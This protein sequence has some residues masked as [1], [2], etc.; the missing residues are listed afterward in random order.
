MPTLLHWFKKPVSD[1]ITLFWEL[2][3]VMV[4]IMVLVRLGVEFG[5][6][7]TVS[8]VFTP[9]MDLVGLPPE[10]GI[11]WTT[12]MLVNIYAAMVALVTLLPEAPMTIAQIT[13]LGTMILLAHS[14]PIEQRIV[15]KAG[16]S[17]IATTLL[18]IISAMVLG[19]ILNSIYGSLELLT[20]MAEIAWLPATA[21]N[22][23]WQEWAID[24]AIS[25]FSIF[26][27]ILLLVL[28]LKALEALKVTDFI[29]KALSPVLGLMGISSSAIPVTMIGVMLG[30]SYGGALI[31]REARE[32]NMSPKDI[33]LSLSFMSLFH[34]A[35]EDTLLIFALGAD[36]SGILIARFI[37]AFLVIF[38][39]S[40][41]LNRLP[42]SVFD[43][44]LFSKT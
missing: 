6:I 32:G 15:Q 18:R 33:F 35:L 16:P 38:I 5:M 29:S 20:E 13:V 9:F 3:K 1:S 14:L 26:W 42:Q 28:I 23:S 25:L 34:S 2:L 4:P 41:L 39:L 10:A 37:F 17:F 21:A 27:I 8:Q 24:S 44:L 43:K 19:A 12:A 40:H 30:L 11:I 36:L 31:L 7:E 22:A